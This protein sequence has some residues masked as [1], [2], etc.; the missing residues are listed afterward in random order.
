MWGRP[1]AIW[2]AVMRRLALKTDH[3]DITKPQWKALDGAL[4]KAHRMIDPIANQAFLELAI[5]GA[6]TINIRSD[7]V[8]EILRDKK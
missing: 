4:R 6:C 2:E 1:N 8:P 5:F 7:G 3:R